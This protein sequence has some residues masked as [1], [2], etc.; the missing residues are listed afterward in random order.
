MFIIR[1]FVG[2]IILFLEKAFSMQV[3]Q[4]DADA[5]SKVDQ[6]TAKLTLYQFQA[7]PFC[8]KVRMSMKRLGLTIQTKDANRS[9]EA[10]GELLVGGGKLTVPCL[11]IEN[12]SGEVT[13]MYESSDIVAYLEGRFMGSQV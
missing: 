13:W 11:K 4:R 2:K 5:Q 6:E 10:R 8:V 3:V 12:D 7:C 9:D 1:L